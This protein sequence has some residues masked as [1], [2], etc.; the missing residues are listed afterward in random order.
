VLLVEH[1]IDLVQTVCDVVTVL[2]RGRVIA[3]GPPAQV[4]GDPVVVTAY[5]GGQSVAELTGQQ[6]EIGVQQ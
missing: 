3:C 1:D 6:E 2:D 4:L 5:L